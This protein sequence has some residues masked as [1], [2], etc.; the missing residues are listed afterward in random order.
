MKIALN[1]T[2]KSIWILCAATF[3][4]LGNVAHA[5]HL[6][7][8]NGLITNLNISKKNVYGSNPSYIVWNG[9]NSDAK[10]VCATFVTLLLQHSYN[11]TNN[12]FQTWMGSNSPSAALYH[13]TILAQNGFLKIAQVNQ[14]HAGDVL[15]IKYF[16][17]A[18]TNTGHAM[19]AA[20]VPVAR[21]ATA[22]IIPGTTQYELLVVDSSKSYHGTADT[23]FISGISGGIGRGTFRIYADANGSIAGYCWSNSSDSTY[24]SPLVRDLVVG[25]IKF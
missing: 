21:T 13:D 16:D 8:A 11:W 20:G 5:D 14:I 10:T 17:N 12:T 6:S 1:R 19:V 7:D 23:R 2:L 25:R 24:Y 18:S 3:V 9:A 15:A 22:P 4:M